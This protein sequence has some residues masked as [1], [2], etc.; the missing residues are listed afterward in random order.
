MQGKMPVGT[1]IWSSGAVA[2]CKSVQL[3]QAMPSANGPERYGTSHCADGDPI[4]ATA[5]DGMQLWR[6]RLG[7]SGATPP[8]PDSKNAVE[9]SR[10]NLDSTSICDSFFV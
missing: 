1:A 6:R 5:A 4:T 2:D 9:P 3:V 8:I 10:I 7:A